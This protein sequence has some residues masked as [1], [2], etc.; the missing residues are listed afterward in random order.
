MQFILKQDEIVDR[1]NY[2]EKA[3]ML[4]RELGESL[5]NKL[6][7]TIDAEDTEKNQKKAK[8]KYSRNMIKPDLQPMQVTTKLN[9]LLRIYKPMDLKEAKQIADEDYLSAY[10]YYCDVI[11]YINQYLVYM[12]DKQTFCAFVNITSDIYNELLYDANYAQVFHSIEDGMVQSN[13]LASQ[14]GIVD[15]TTT[16]AKLQTKDAGHNLVKNPESITFNTYNIADQRQ[17]N[18]QLEKFDSMTKRI[19]KK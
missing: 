10:G 2:Q 9:R 12:P 18:L 8:S 16:M 6:D 1:T 4:I 3:D 11:D 19:A 14:A 15:R 7:D 13:F 5:F 17:V